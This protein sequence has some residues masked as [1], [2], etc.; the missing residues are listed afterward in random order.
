MFTIYMRPMRTA[1]F[2]IISSFLSVFQLY[3]QTE[4]K[5][6]DEMLADGQ[7]SRERF[8]LKTNL[9]TMPS[10][11]FPLYAEL[12]LSRK[13][14][15]EAGVGFQAKYFLRE[16]PYIAFGKQPFAIEPEGNLEVSGGYSLRVFPRYYLVGD[17][18]EG[19][20]IGPFWRMRQ[21]NIQASDEKVRFTD[22]CLMYSQQ[23]GIKRSRFFYEYYLGLGVRT[24]H[25]P[26]G[27]TPVNGRRHFISPWGVK[28]GYGF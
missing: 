18:L 19:I 27:V 11:D 17:N 25:F 23:V 14:S 24:P 21:Y 7:K 2:C 13:F 8:I 16:W 26:D 1:I 10:G 4:E 12:R 20:V 9:A 6:M 15:L 3:A 5:T 28:I 22:L